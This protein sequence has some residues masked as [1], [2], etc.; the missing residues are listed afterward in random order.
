MTEPVYRG[1][2]W[3][4]LRRQVIARDRGVCQLCGEPVTGAGRSS[5]AASVDHIVP[6]S[7]GGARYDTVNLRLVHVRCNTW[8][9]L[10]PHR[11]QRRTW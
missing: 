3:A 7:A 10:R 6:V 8:L 1:E 9:A 4:K 5:G 2:R 11:R